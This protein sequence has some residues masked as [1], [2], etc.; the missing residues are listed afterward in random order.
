MMMSQVHTQGDLYPDLHV[1]SLAVRPGSVV[2]ILGDAPSLAAFMELA[3][4]LT[5]PRSG[6]VAVGGADTTSLSKQERTRLRAGHLGL[7]FA[8]SAL[9]LGADVA[10]NIAR[11]LAFVGASRLERR[12]AAH[13]ILESSGFDAWLTYPAADLGLPERRLVALFRALVTMPRV[14]FLERSFD[15]LDGAV[16]R[17]FAEVV[18]RHVA[19]RGAVIV[20]AANE[21]DVPLAIDEWFEIVSGTLR[22][23]RE[24]LRAAAEPLQ[25]SSAGGVAGQCHLEVAAIEIRLLAEA[26]VI[27]DGRTERLRP[28]H[29]DLVAMLAQNPDG[30]NGE[31]LHADVFGDAASMSTLRAELTRL[32][33][34]LPIERRPY[35]IAIDFRA[36]FLR[37]LDAAR[38]GNVDTVV[39]L[40]RGPLLPNSSAP[41][42]I[43]LRETLEATVRRAVLEHGEARHVIRVAEVL[44]DDLELWEAASQRLAPDDPR[45]PYVSARIDVIRRQ[46]S[47]P[48]DGSSAGFRW[49]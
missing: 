39:A 7:V 18:R 49:S 20:L 42:V 26:S 17:Q 22:R 4:L 41:G 1:P 13:A 21:D 14:L 11:P 24:G 5:V 6:V 47:V 10:D 8:N 31:R 3:S 43:S 15:D 48:E 25:I 23:R 2:V 12:N 35:R 33:S 28:R 32:R 37:V 9:D 40:Y 30:V 19:A 36:D 34:V 44:G 45:A 27:I 29:A 16:A 38:I 46:W